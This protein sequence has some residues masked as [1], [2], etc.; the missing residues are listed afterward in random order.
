MPIVIKKPDDN[1]NNLNPYCHLKQD[2][3]FQFLNDT[4]IR[5]MAH[6]KFF[7]RTA[8]FNASKEWEKQR[9][10]FFKTYQS[11]QTIPLKP[12]KLSK[13]LTYQD[14]IDRRKSIRDFK[15]IPMDFQKLSGTMAL[16]FFEKQDHKRRYPS[17]GACYP[18]E[19][20]FI[21]INVKGLDK[22]VYHL[23]LKEKAFKKILDEDSTEKLLNAVFHGNFQDP[24]SQNP[25]GIVIITSI[26][27]RTIKKYGSRGWRFLLM[28]AGFV[29]QLFAQ[30]CVACGIGCYPYG[31]GYDSEIQSCL[32]LNPLQ[33]A[34]LLTFIVGSL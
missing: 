11:R 19:S 24:L 15:P 14:V 21:S 12:L 1:N 26:F 6:L 9:K 20:Y 33:E 13:K 16:T 10:T 28:E 17:G 27:E 25:G 29:G 4:K 32:G 22:G 31:G 7:Q 18:T 3:G 5:P 23:N 30:N 2:I 34:P 8:T